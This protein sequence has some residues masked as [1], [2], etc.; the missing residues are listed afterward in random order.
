MAKKLILPVF[1]ALF[2][3]FIVITVVIQVL[4]G[5][6]VRQWLND[7]LGVNF[8]PV[9]FLA[10]RAIFFLLGL[11]LIILTAK[12]EIDRT[13]KK[14][15]I[16]SGSSAIGVSVG[17]LLHNLVSGV[18]GGEEPFFFILA[19]FVCPVAFLVGAVGSIVLMVRRKKQGSQIT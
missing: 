10:S 1:W 7:S 12:A 13:L 15:L 19:V 5:P 4:M 2:G 18:I 17:V 11:A 6:P 9:L 16:L 14:F 8:V 3:A